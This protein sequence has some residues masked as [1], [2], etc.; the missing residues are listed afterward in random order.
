MTA[1]HWA[2]HW[3][4]RMVAHSAGNSDVCSADYWVDAK[5]VYWVG[6]L[7]AHSAGKKDVMKADN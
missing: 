5:A 4:D 7:A 2:A 1:A 6:Y 3:A